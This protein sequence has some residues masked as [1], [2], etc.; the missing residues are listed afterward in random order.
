[1]SFVYG[2]CQ[3]F[4]LC[5]VLGLCLVW[6]LQWWGVEHI[7]L[8]SVLGN[9]WI[10]GLCQAFVWRARTSTV[11]NGLQ[12]TTTDGRTLWWTRTPWRTSVGSQMRQYVLQRAIADL[13]HVG[14]FVC[15]SPVQILQNARRSARIWLLCCRG[16]TT[17]RGKPRSQ[18]R[19]RIL[20]EPGRLK[21]AEA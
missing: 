17:A 16:S 19:L 8:F 6:G 15:P 11:V 12:Q 7:A 13:D 4:V 3:S 5:H 1:M 10:W 18:S 21:R 14:R 2:L 20:R 9:V